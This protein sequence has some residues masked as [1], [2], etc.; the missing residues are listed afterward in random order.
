M[1]STLEPT[2]ELYGLVDRVSRSIKKQFR[3]MEPDDLR[4]EAWWWLSKNRRLVREHHDNVGY[5]WTSIRHHLAKYSRDWLAADAGYETEDQ[6]YY[7]IS[8]LKTLLACAFTP[9]WMMQGTSYDDIRVSGGDGHHDPADAWAMVADVRV[10]Y[11]K[12]A[13]KD[14]DLLWRA[15]GEPASTQFKDQIA[16]LAA[17]A[18]IERNVANQRVNDALG[19]MRR[20]LG[21]GKPRD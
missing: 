20:H 13:Q 5:L 8:Q 18:G 4:Q 1:T 12:L 14:K 19:R 15:I 10:A 21:G 11:S 2:E 16:A 9:E 17:E 7:T 6:H 3:G